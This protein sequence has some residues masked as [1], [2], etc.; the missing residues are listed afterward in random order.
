M[1]II[2]KKYEEAV[3]ERLRN[4]GLYTEDQIINASIS[5]VNPN[6][7]G[8]R[9]F[10]VGIPI[11]TKQFIK[12][13]LVDQLDK[14]TEISAWLAFTLIGNGI[15]FLGKCI[16][17]TAPGWDKPGMSRKNFNDAI[18]QLRGLKKY[19]YLIK[20]QD[21]FDLY[22]QFRCG[23]THELG[24]K[25]GVTLSSK[26]E[27]KNLTEFKGAINFHINDLFV[28]FKTACE[29]VINREFPTGNKMNKPRIFI[30]VIIPIRKEWIK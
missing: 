17:L 16:D 26:D 29:E 4:E 30:N 28:D 3:R 23:L 14:V 5:E 12:T 7:H 9:R 8:D 1:S 15:E 25:G 21:G 11:F 20:R 27:A 24:P 22:E 6:Q 2:Y 19:E 10:H 13:V 18:R